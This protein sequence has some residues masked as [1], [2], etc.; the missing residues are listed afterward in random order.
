MSTIEE[1]AAKL[2]ERTEAD[3][4][5]A[6][7]FN[8]I[9]NVTGV[10]ESIREAV[11]PLGKRIVV[12]VHEVEGPPEARKR[13][14]IWL[15]QTALY[16]RFVDLR[17]GVGELISVTYLGESDHHEPGQSPAKRFRVEVDRDGQAFSWPLADGSTES[18][19]PTEDELTAAQERIDHERRVDAAADAAERTSAQLRPD[20][21]LPI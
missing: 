12:Q 18:P 15:S 5:A 7:D 20:D 2:R 14:A 1:R 17:V 8:E 9:P 11:G 16:N 21:D 13:Y 6:W 3:Y 4:P 19:A 10:V